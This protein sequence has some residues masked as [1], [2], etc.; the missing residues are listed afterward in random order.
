M[1]DFITNAD[2]SLSKVAGPDGR[3]TVRTRARAVEGNMTDLMTDTMMRRDFDPAMAAYILSAN[4]GIQVPM[5]D[6]IV[7]YLH[8]ITIDG[9]DPEVVAKANKMLDSLR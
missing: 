6:F 9:G 8:Q 4:D 5:L 3:K 1:A 2:G 7:G